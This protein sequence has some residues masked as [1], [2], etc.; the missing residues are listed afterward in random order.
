MLG[1]G[2][3]LVSL[4]RLYKAML[5]LSSAQLILTVPMLH[6]DDAPLLSVAIALTA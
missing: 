4:L 3:D 6:P 5:D 1:V 2:I